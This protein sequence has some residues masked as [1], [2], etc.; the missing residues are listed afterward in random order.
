MVV[1]P[2]PPVG[3]VFWSF[4]GK[5]YE[6]MEYLKDSNRLV[7]ITFTAINVVFFWGLIVLGVDPSTI[8]DLVGSISTEDGLIAVIAPLGTFILS[9]LLPADAK[10]RLVYWRY[11]DPLPGSWAFSKHLPRE[12]RA[13][14]DRLIE[15]WGQ[16]PHDPSEQNRL[17]YKIYRSVDSELRVHESHR[18]WLRSRDL[19][20]YTALFL[21]FLGIPAIVMDSTRD[22]V[23]WYLV[24][25]LAQYLLVMMA[26]RN[27]GIRFVRTVLAVASNSQTPEDTTNG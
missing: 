1:T 13:D 15:R 25:L 27:Y 12:S 17:W 7:L 16:L 8:P 20:G 6:T 23:V 24:A 21:F 11:R 3:S 14:P 26:A 4:L 5:G 10:D 18:A 22:V 9:G 2:E 19:T